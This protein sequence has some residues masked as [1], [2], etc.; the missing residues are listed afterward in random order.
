MMFSLQ[1]YMYAS[2]KL[3]SNLKNLEIYT[4]HHRLFVYIRLNLHFSVISIK[5][6]GATVPGYGAMWIYIFRQHCHFS[7]E[8]NVPL[9]LM[10]LGTTRRVQFKPKI[11]Q[12]KTKALMTSLRS[13]RN[14]FIGVSTYLQY[15][16]SPLYYNTF[17]LISQRSLIQ[18]TISQ[19]F[20]TIQNIYIYIFF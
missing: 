20:I 19:E 17:F 11:N 2:L 5:H 15:T 4:Q 3:L 7:D 1:L 14:Q 6:N 10:C 13:V 9:T 12:I 16:F 18:P 8:S